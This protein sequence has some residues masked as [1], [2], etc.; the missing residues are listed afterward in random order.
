MISGAE[1]RREKKNRISYAGTVAG[2]SMPKPK[3]VRIVENITERR[4]E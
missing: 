1:S 4:I 2:P 3:F